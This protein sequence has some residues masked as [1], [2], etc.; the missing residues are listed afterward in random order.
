VEEGFPPL[1]VTGLL[2]TGLCASLPPNVPAL[3]FCTVPGVKVPRAVDTPPPN[4][5]PAGIAPTW[6]CCIV[7]RRV[8]VC[9]WNEAG[10][11][12]LLGVLPKKRSD[13]PLRIV[14]GA[15]ARPLA[16]KLVRVGTTGKL[17]AI[18]RAPFN[19]CR[20][21]GCGCI[22]PPPKRPASTVDM[23]RKM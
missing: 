20:V 4:R 15:A 18:K 5:P 3:G 17:P 14:D 12:P 8:A 2:E 22:L 11:T 19:C 16:D 9:C 7:C 23:A 13:P 1:L 6:C 10:R 21:I